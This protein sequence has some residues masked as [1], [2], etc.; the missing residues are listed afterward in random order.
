MCAKRKRFIALA[1]IL[2]LKSSTTEKKGGEIV[3]KQNACARYL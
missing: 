2:S 3:K 1:I